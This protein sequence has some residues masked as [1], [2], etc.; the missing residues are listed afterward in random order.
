MLRLNTLLG[1]DLVVCGEEG[2]EWRIRGPLRKC[3]N[4]MEE[5]NVCIWL[6]L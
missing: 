3:G 6:V 1:K 4:G 2:T 5:G